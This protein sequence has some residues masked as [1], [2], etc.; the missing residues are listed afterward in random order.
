[1]QLDD[2]AGKQA[3]E[4]AR[5]YVAGKISL[6]MPNGSKRE[7]YLGELGAEIDKVRLASLVRQA[8]DRTSMLVRGFRASGQPGPLTLPVP[9]S[10]NVDRAVAALRPLKD[11]ADR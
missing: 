6:E 11:E 1:M 3:L 2:S 9:V 4:R 8:K 7:L 10:L 5:R